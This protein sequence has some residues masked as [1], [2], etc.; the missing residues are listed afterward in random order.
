MRYS[1]WDE[2]V[3]KVDDTF[4][5]GDRIFSRLKVMIIGFDVDCDDEHAQ[6]LCYI[7]SYERIPCGFDTFTIDKYHV[8]HFDLDPK[9]TGDAG[10]FITAW[11]PT[12]AHHPA[13]KG[14]NCSKCGDFCVGVSADDSDQPYR[15]RSCRE[16]PYR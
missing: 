9:F 15:C 13:P 2:V 5:Y 1:L 8:R 4:G 6:Y 11:T 16:N 12:F 10:C 3:L 7:P 14:E